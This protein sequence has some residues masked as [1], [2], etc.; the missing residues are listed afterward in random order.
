M[1]NNYWN[2]YTL[3]IYI[4]YY[5]Y[6]YIINYNIILSFKETINYNEANKNFH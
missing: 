4:Y 3:I 6:I 1:K 2:I 5:L